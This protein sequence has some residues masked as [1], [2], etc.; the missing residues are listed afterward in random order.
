MRWVNPS[1]FSTSPHQKKDVCRLISSTPTCTAWKEAGRSASLELSHNEELHSSP[2]RNQT[3]V[4]LLLTSL[5]TLP[6]L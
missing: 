6:C 1:Q 5:P 2:L 4:K 3:T